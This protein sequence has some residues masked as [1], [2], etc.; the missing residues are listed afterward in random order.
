MLADFVDIVLEVVEKEVEDRVVDY[1]VDIVLEE[2]EKEA[3]DRVVDYFVED[4]VDVG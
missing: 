3:L 2:D 4:K 1:F